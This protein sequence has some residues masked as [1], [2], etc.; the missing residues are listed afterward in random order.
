[1]KKL[2]T[3]VLALLMVLSLVACSPA[4]TPAESPAEEPAAETPADGGDS[5]EAP[6]AEGS[7]LEPVVLSQN[8]LDAEKHGNHARNEFVKEKFNLTYEYIPVSWGDWNEKI[9]TWV[10][11]DDAPDLIN[12]DLK[13]A[14]STEYLSGEPAYR[15][16]LPADWAACRWPSAA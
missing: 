10:S 13:A 6:A 12:W 9:R 15:A 3:L 5:G 14:S 4:Q 11:T 2:L 16:V 8:V 1:M 7:D